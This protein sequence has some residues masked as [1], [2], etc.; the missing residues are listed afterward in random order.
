M[1]GSFDGAQVIQADF[2]IPAQCNWVPVFDAYIVCVK[3]EFGQ[4]ASIEQISESFSSFVSIELVRGLPSSPSESIRLL[5]EE[6]RP[7]PRLGRQNG[8]GM[9]T[10]VG[11][12]IADAMLHVC[13]VVLSHNTIKG[14]AGG[15]LKNAELLVKKGLI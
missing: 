14:A 9:A 8:D 6:D 3:V 13:Y 15:S 2:G 10:M 12:V 7:Q 5:T 11:R 4:A 1:L